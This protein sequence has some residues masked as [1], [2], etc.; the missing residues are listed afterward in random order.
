M[1]NLQDLMELT[2]KCLEQSISTTHSSEWF[3]SFSGHVNGLS[4]TYHQGGWDLSFKMS[5]HPKAK[6]T[7]ASFGCPKCDVTLDEAGIQ[8]AYWFI[9]NRL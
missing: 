9:A 7:S 1:K 2:A 8:E 4:I 3:I 5:Q 6:S